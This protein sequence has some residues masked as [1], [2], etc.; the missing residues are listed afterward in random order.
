[1]GSVQALTL[2]ASPGS[3]KQPKYAGKQ[4]VIPEN[5]IVITREPWKQKPEREFLKYRKYQNS[6]PGGFYASNR[7]SIFQQ[8]YSRQYYSD[9]GNKKS[10]ACIIIIF[11]K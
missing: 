3:M 9:K 6:A 8:E 1:M 7:K 4:N 10:N 11:L 2:Q 5:T